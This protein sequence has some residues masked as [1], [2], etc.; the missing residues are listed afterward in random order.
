MPSVYCARADGTVELINEFH[1][2]DF[3]RMLATHSST[4]PGRS[5]IG[6]CAPGYVLER[7]P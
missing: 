1:Y 3:K 2:G 4:P 5:R 6:T 7:Q